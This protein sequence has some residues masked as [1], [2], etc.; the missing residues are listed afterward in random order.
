MMNFS[1]LMQ[2][3]AGKV[4][5]KAYRKH[6][7]RNEHAPPFKSLRSALLLLFKEINK[8]TFI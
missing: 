4:S 3:C 8:P 7:Q 5:S 2:D 6:Q 1:W